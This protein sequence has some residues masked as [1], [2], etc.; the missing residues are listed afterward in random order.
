[1]TS[2][3]VIVPTHNKAAY[4]ELSLASWER[5][6]YHD[7]ELVIV[8]DGSTDETPEV[9]ARYRDRLPISHERTP[10]RGRAA[11][12][13]RAIEL[14]RGELLVFCDDDRVVSAEFV[15][16]HV[17]MFDDGKP[18]LVLGWQ[19][20]L[21]SIWRADVHFDRLLLW[22]LLSRGTVGRAVDQE[23]PVRLFEADDLRARFGEIIERFSFDE[24]FWVDACMPVIERFGIELRGY[25]VP[26][27]LG[28]TGNMSIRK[29]DAERVGLFDHGFTGWGLEDLDLC[30]RLAHVGVPTTICREA[31]NYHQAHPSAG[32][33][34]QWLDNLLHFMHK[35][36]HF[37]AAFYA[38]T[39][40][41]PAVVDLI[42]FNRLYGELAR[43]EV[44]PA[45]RR[46]LRDAWVRL[47]EERVHKLL[48]SEVHHLVGAN[49]DEW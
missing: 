16:S 19:E 36:E 10:N 27:V 24:R 25:D 46:A 34:R 44:A 38:Y 33:R 14:A 17:R 41:R 9:I 21:L 31:V 35:Y 42:E 23:G 32:R 37:D 15:G 22:R 48:W 40:T 45:L 8:D 7:Y 26:W 39:F 30:Y 12:R 2:A 13:S 1:M 47:V 11:A 20:G 5:Q 3:S 29:R 4:L 49:H 43:D 6:R 18:H 28:T